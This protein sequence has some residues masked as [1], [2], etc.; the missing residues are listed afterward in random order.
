MLRDFSHCNGSGCLLRDNCQ[1]YTML[2]DVPKDEDD[3]SMCWMLL[4][5]YSPAHGCINFVQAVSEPVI[6]FGVK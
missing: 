5:Q 1:R 3:T 6:E 2:K 4:E